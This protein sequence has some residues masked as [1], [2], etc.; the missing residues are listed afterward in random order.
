MYNFQNPI[1]KINKTYNPS[2]QY[3]PF[4]KVVGKYY[5]NQTRT[6]NFCGKLGNKTITDQRT[7]RAKYY[8][9]LYIGVIIGHN[10]VRKQP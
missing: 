3:L 9:P 10:S 6:A 7:K 2:F 4:S 5:Q 1:T 8:A